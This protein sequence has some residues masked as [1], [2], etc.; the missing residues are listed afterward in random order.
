V[1]RAKKRYSVKKE[2]VKSYL[3]NYYKQ[4]SQDIKSSA[5][6]YYKENREQMKEKSKSYY[7]K[8]REKINQKRREKTEKEWKELLGKDY[9]GVSHVRYKNERL[10][11]IYLESLFPNSKIAPFRINAMGELDQKYVYVDYSFKIGQNRILV[12]YNGRQHYEPTKFKGMKEPS[13]IKFL[14]QQKRDNWLRNYSKIKG[15]KLIEIDGRYIKKE[16]IK[17]FLKTELKEFL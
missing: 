2:E 15:Y 14:R 9:D 13:K 5:N 4:N 6:K 17:E 10:T 1:E 8:N 11:K 12:E 7:E 16:N 3:K